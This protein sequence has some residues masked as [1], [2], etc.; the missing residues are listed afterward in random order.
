MDKKQKFEIIESSK[1]PRRE[2]IIKALISQIQEPEEKREINVE[3]YTKQLIKTIEVYEEKY[4][5]KKGELVVWKEGL[6]NKKVPDYNIPAVVIEI[7]TEPI[8]DENAPLASPYYKEELNL[9]LAILDEDNELLTFH[10]DGY[11]FKPFK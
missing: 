8:I 4:E 2:E 7:Y 9:K 3:E 5:F 10:Y 6:K 11:R 1:S